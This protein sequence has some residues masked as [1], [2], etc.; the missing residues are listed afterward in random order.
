[1]AKDKRTA[2]NISTLQKFLK[3]DTLLPV[4]FFFGE[5]HYSI[6]A[7]LR[8]IEDLVRPM[9]DSEFDREVISGKDKTI[10]EVLDMASSFPFGSGKRL[11]I[12]KDFD[13]DKKN[14]KA[15]ASYVKDPPSFTV[16]VIIKYGTISGF[17]TEPYSILCD[18]NY[19]FECKEPKRDE[20]VSWI[21]RE[22]VKKNK[23]ISPENAAL[24]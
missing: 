7:A 8:A 13:S 3:K 16:L 15:L 9:L 22:V 10:T 23:V 14:K 1:M 11:I 12:F 6:E 2:P 20:L 4:Y 24:L 19:M 21:E 17:E 18:K 5:D